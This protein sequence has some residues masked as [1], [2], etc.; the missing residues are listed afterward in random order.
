MCLAGSFRHDTGRG[1]LA[2]LVALACLLL[3]G[4]GPAD[5]RDFA[6]HRVS[7]GEFVE[8]PDDR[9]WAAAN[10]LMVDP[11]QVAF[12]ADGT[13]LVS[14]GFSHR[15][16][17]PDWIETYVWLHRYSREGEL[18]EVIYSSTSTDTGA[19]SLDWYF[20]LTPD[21]TIARSP[22]PLAIDEDGNQYRRV[23]VESSRT[24]FIVKTNARGE[25]AKEWAVGGSTMLMGLD[26]LLYVQHRRG[27]GFWADLFLIKA[28]D[29][30]GNLIRQWEWSALGGLDAVDPIGRLYFGY[31]DLEDDPRIQQYSP[32]GTALGWVEDAGGESFSPWLVQAVSQDGYLVAADEHSSRIHLFEFIPSRFSD[33]SLWHWAMCD[34]E[35][36]AEGGIVQGFPDG[37]YEPSLPVDR[38]QMAVYLA[39]ALAGSDEAVPPGPGEPSFSDVPADHWAYRHVEYVTEQGL[40]RGFTDRRY[41]PESAV[42]RAQMAVFLARAIAGSDRDVP[43]CPFQPTFEDVTPLGRWL[44]CYRHVEYLASEGVVTGYPDGCYRP[45]AVVTRAQMAVYVTRAFEVPF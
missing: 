14:G 7:F 21:G 35:A 33:I 25:S 2:A 37:A 12:D 11:R 43:F 3:Y 30:E 1:Y 38:A 18:E 41:C 27:W 20:A 5:A 44:W 15:Y 31:E 4:A 39:R 8:T 9:Q 29:R 45:G 16:S 17:E 32:D 13:I 6:T 19:E 40:V 26:G 10:G 23:F 24:V 34:I 42:D 28:Y 36:L 22:V